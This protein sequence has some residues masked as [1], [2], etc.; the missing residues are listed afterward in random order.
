MLEFVKRRWNSLTRIYYND[1]YVGGIFRR[2]TKRR[3][4]QYYLE[5]LGVYYFPLS[6]EPNIGRGGWCIKDFSRK[7]DAIEFVKKFDPKFFENAK[8]ISIKNGWNEMYKKD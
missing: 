7:K 2:N 6:E 8:D 1:V 4:H 5:I 3:K